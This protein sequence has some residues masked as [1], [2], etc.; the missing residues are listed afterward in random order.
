MKLNENIF[1]QSINDTIQ[2]FVLDVLFKGNTIYL[3]DEEKSWLK[4]SVL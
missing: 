3:T 1:N 2:T 4:A